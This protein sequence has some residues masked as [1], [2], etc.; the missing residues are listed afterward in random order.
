VVYKLNCNNCEATFVDQT[1]RQLKTRIAEHRNY[2][3]INTSTH[4]VITDH[5]IISD[6]D[7]DWDNVRDFGCE[8]EF[9]QKIDF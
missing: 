3:K 2:I 9:E 8:K 4:S 6:H 1:K 7:F 5:R